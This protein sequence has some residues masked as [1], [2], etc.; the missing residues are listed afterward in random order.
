MIVY[1]QIEYTHIEYTITVYIHIECTQRAAKTMTVY[2][3]IE[4][5]MTVYASIRP[6]RLQPY[7]WD[8]ISVPKYCPHVVVEDN[9]EIRLKTEG[10][11]LRRA[12]IADAP[13]LLYEDYT[14]RCIR[15]LQALI[16]HT[17]TYVQMY[18]PRFEQPYM[19]NTCVKVC[20]STNIPMY[21]QRFEHTDI[22]TIHINKTYADVCMCL[23]G[24]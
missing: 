19:Q 24:I 5:A 22:Q 15:N 1:T 10:G 4:Y 17:R 3:H 20:H 13:L 14:S 11:Q 23:H 6:P 7:D 8:K 9:L 2:T 12:K 18:A 16:H 21:A